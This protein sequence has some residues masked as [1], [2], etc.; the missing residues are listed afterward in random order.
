MGADTQIRRAD[1]RIQEEILR[2]A[3]SRLTI[4]DLG[5]GEVEEF[6]HG[7]ENVEECPT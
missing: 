4:L 5:Y 1:V 7:G 6:I 2:R 3:S